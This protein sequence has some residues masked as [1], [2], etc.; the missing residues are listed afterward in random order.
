MIWTR[1][2]TTAHVVALTFDAG[3]NGDGLPSILATLN[4]T[5]VRASFFLTGTFARTYPA[6]A[7]DIVEGGYRVGDHST[8]HPYFTRLANPQ[9]DSE[10]LG[11][12]Q[13]I[14]AVGGDRFVLEPVFCI[15]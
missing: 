2:P 10:V 8:D 13:T 9:V 3:A 1:I 4:S 7:A 15:T 11:A 6:L 12:A 14:K 5:G